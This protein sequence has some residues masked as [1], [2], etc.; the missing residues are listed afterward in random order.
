MTR[1][2]L[3]VLALGV[4]SARA[5]AQQPDSLP[6]DSVMFSA[7]E[8]YAAFSLTLPE[9]DAY[10]MT[11]A[12]ST[13]TVKDKGGI[14]IQKTRGKGLSDDILAMLALT[15][16]TTAAKVNIVR[17]AGRASIPAEEEKKWMEKLESMAKLARGTSRKP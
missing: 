2:S 1:F 13:F 4:L 11:K 16:D 8:L 3:I 17:R 15:S 9:A 5:A 14:E 7:G 12:F 6:A 10:R